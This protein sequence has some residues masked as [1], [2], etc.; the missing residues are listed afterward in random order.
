MGCA[1][2]KDQLKKTDFDEHAQKLDCQD[3][4]F[5]GMVAFKCL[6]Q[7]HMAYNIG[8]QQSIAYLSLTVETCSPNHKCNQGQELEES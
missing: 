4:Q 8:Q 5:K 7:K 6:K 2:Q 1:A 3:H